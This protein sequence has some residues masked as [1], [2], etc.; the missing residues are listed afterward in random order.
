[1]KKRSKLGML[2]AGFAMAVAGLMGGAQASQPLAQQT[3]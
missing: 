1:M 3:Q 2:G